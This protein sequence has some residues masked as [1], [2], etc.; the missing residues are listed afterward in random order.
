MNQ[1]TL[2]I[3]VAIIGSGFEAL[4]PWVLDRIALPW[5]FAAS[6]HPY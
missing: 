3:I 1:E 4:V 2:T 5:V 6:D